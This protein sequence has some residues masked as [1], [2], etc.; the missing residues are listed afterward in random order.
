MFSAAA[1]FEVYD[2]D[3]CGGHAAN[4]GDISI[5]YYLRMI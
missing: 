1:E 3:V 4:G 2:L 5:T